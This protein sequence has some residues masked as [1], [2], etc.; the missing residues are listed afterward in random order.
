MQRDE[1]A[2]VGGAQTGAAVEGR[3]V[4]DGEL[5]KV[6][7]NHVGLD[8]NDDVTAAVVNVDDVADHLGEDDHVTQVGADGLGLVQHI[9]LTLL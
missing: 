1:A 3:L 6:L 8:L 4:G 9:T 5:A 2:A 7:A